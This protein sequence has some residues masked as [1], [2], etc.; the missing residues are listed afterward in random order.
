MAELAPHQAPACRGG[1]GRGQSKREALW[2]AAC[3]R[4]QA[5]AATQTG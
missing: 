1:L 4:K 2:V 3:L 5:L